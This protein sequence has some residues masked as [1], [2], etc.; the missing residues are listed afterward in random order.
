MM[1]ILLSKCEAIDP[2]QHIPC[3]LTYELGGYVYNANLAMAIVDAANEAIDPLRTG[4]F[5]PMSF[6]PV[7]ATQRQPLYLINGRPC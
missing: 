3:G 1:Q 2:S 4:E 5:H 7:V 6:N